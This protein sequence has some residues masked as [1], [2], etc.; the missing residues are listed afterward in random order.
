M[1]MTKLLS[2]IACVLI[3]GSM[4]F[5]Q[6]GADGAG[7]GSDA[8]AELKDP[9]G[10]TVGDVRFIDTPNGLLLRAMVSG[11]PAGTHAM[12]LHA[13]GLCEAPSFE[14]AGGHFNP[15]TQ[16]HGCLDAKGPHRGDLPNIHMSPTPLQ[17]DVFVADVRLRTGPAMLLDGDGAAVVIHAGA[18]DYQSEPAGDAG[19]RLACGVVGGS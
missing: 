8:R 10:R 14:S 2:V 6:T 18:D 9:S 5:T 13:T 16:E 3:S 7:T 4:A 17:L 19:K 12:H 15:D 1:K 11:L